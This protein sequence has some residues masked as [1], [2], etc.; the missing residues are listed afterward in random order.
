MFTYGITSTSIIPHKGFD[1]DYGV[2]IVNGLHFVPTIQHKLENEGATA[3]A[4]RDPDHQVGIAMDLNEKRRVH[5]WTITIGVHGKCRVLDENGNLIGI[6]IPETDKE[7]AEMA[8]DIEFVDG[9][10][11]ILSLGELK[12]LF[13][14]LKEQFGEDAQGYPVT[15]H[16]LDDPTRDEVMECFSVINGTAKP[17]SKDLLLWFDYQRGVLQGHPRRMMDLLIK[18][19]S[20]EDHPL[21]G[22]IKL[23]KGTGY[24][25]KTIVD[26]CCGGSRDLIA[27]MELAGFEDINSQYEVFMKIWNS[28]I[29]EVV[30]DST[31]G[32]SDQDVF[33]GIAA[34]RVAYATSMGEAALNIM[35]HEENPEYS[36]EKFSHIYHLWMSQILKVKSIRNSD[37]GYTS[38][39]TPKGKYLLSVENRWNGRACARR[40][41]Q[42]DHSLLVLAYKDQLRV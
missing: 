38:Y 18:A 42:Q 29:E 34:N 23:G 40:A 32:S 31:R 17:M 13:E 6:N 8:K 21:C 27:E 2:G 15:I 25:A 33:K 16:V 7:L 20:D 30:S 22:R 26:I 11:R 9:Q 4:Q 12:E 28:I 37:N 19:N 24:S 1:G 41:I 36:V 5:T 39:Y 3:T 10:N 35:R 14:S